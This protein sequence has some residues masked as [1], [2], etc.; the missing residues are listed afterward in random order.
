MISNYDQIHSIRA[1]LP[2]EILEDLKESFKTVDL[3]KYYKYHG[4]PLNCNRKIQIYSKIKDI[5]Q[6]LL[7]ESIDNEFGITSVSLRDRAF[8]HHLLKSH[9]DYIVDL[10]KNYTAKFY[11]FYVLSIGDQPILCSKC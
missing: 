3:M 1:V 7:Q 8:V 10:Q 2:E 11:D 4:Y 9:R 6:R 5:M